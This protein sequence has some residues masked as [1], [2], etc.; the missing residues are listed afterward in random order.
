MVLN[1]QQTLVDL[2]YVRDLCLSLDHINKRAA[3]EL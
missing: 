2:Q 1:T 3:S